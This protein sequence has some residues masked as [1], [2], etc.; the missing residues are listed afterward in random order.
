[1]IDERRLRVLLAVARGGSLSAAA[2]L[3]GYTQPA[4]SHHVGRLEDEVGVKVL[5]RAPG[6]M[7]LTAAGELLA[8][9]AAAI[10]AHV[11]QAQAELDDLLGL[12]AGTVAVGAYP[13]AFVDLVPGAVA[14]LR[15]EH[16]GLLVELRAADRAAGVRGLHDGSLDVAVVFRDPDEPVAWAGDLRVRP[17]MEDPMRVVLPRGHRLAGR[18]VVPLRDLAEDPWILGS[19]PD[20]F[21]VRAARAAG[22]EPR[23]AHTADDLLAVQ[24]FVAA[25]LGVALGPGLGM[26]STRDDVLVREVAVGGRTLR[27]EI[28]A[29]SR[30]SPSPAAARTL[31]ALETVA[32][33]TRTASAA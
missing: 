15:R 25:G 32:A 20:G 26:P 6:G 22:F 23:R 28:F 18:A 31:D 2:D 7:R 24:G 21:T 17:L 19:D 11:Q 13:T 16:P 3:L 10:E 14:E 5:E 33:A 27:R 9:R 4:I 30:A 12:R 29:I 8:H 1:M